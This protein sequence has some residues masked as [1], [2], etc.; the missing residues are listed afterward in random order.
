MNSRKET[1]IIVINKDLVARLQMN[2][3]LMTQSKDNNI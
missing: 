1:I 2:E 3:V